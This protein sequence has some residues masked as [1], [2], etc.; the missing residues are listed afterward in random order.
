MNKSKK[1][2]IT[3]MALAILSCIGIAG[4]S[5]YFTDGDTA[6]NTFLVGKVSL[7]LT[8]PNWSADPQDI[9]PNQEFAK[10]PVITNDGV[11]D[12]FVFLEVVMPYKN[13]ETAELD[14]TRNAATD[15]ELFSILKSDGTVGINDGWVKVGTPRKDESKGTITHVYA[16]A[17]DGNMTALTANSKTVALFDKVR[18]C[19]AVEDQ[20]LEGTSRDI[21]INAYGIQTT[22]INDTAGGS[23]TDGKT[24][25]ADVWAVVSAQAPATSE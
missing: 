12:E 3:A 7:N 2:K 21:V 1:I 13:I 25:P 4:V 10:D 11:N 9:T 5:A 19:N 16:Y 8:E 23:N 20:G 22:N 17:S 18:F 15:T 14:G 24:A 6:T